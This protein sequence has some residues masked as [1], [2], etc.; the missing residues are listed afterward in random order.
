MQ[1]LQSDCLKKLLELAI[2]SADRLTTDWQHF[3]VGDKIHPLVVT[4][5]LLDNA[6]VFWALPAGHIRFE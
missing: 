3:K 4:A 6:V 1:R 5:V 2:N